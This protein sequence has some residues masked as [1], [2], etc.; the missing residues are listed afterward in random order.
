MYAQEKRFTMTVSHDTILAYNDFTVTFSIENL[1]GKFNPPSFEPFNIV[2]GPNTSSSFSM[3]NGVI[4]QS[5][6][7][8]YVLSV[9]TPGVYLLEGATMDTD[10]EVITTGSINIVVLDNPERVVQRERGMSSPI[11]RRSVMVPMVR[12]TLSNQDSIRYQLRDL[13]TRKI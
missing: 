3:I 12:D 11:H 9:T 6:S 4:K 8:S 7:Y 5:S 13:K 2:A 1:Q 10:G